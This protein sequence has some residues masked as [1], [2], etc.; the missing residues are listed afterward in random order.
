M[1]IEFRT[2]VYL[3]KKAYNISANGGWYT[4][5]PFTIFGFKLV[6]Y[7]DDGFFTLIELST[8]FFVVGIYGS[9]LD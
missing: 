8:L 5:N 1:S 2:R 6:E 9:K 4:G 3:K 7:D